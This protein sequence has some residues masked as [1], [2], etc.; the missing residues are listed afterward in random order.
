MYCRLAKDFFKEKS[1]TYTEHNV[2]SD[3]KKR[4]EMFKASG[5]MGVPVIDIDG[6]LT[7]GFDKERIKKLLG[8]S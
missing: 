5:Q 1:V 4:D 7:V 8:I 3:V 6:Q 2:Q